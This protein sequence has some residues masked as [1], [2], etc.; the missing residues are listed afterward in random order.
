METAKSQK[1]SYNH[2]GDFLLKRRI[3]HRGLHNAQR[4]IPENSLL[5]FEL[6]VEH[7]Y[8]IELD[9]HLSRDGRVVVMHDNRLERMTGAKGKVTRKTYAELKKL[10]LS[11]TDQGVPLLEEVLRLVDGRVP[12]VVEL[13]NFKFWNM[14]LEKAT[15][16]IM[17][18]Y[19]GKYAMKSFNPLTVRYLQKHHPEI[20]RGQLVPDFKKLK[21]GGPCRWLL[22]KILMSFV[23][24][25]ELDFISC[26]IG[27]LQNEQIQRWRKEK[28]V[29]GWTIRSEADLARAQKWCDNVIFEGI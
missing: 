1:S 2:R 25:T 9:V 13:K 20:V 3:A 6:A 8:A 27:Y 29:L 7:K 10:K 18:S 15:V 24:R 23:K 11:G 22:E 14:K 16:E 19:S 5:A 12:V 28:P 21:I 17:Q 26:G 4:G